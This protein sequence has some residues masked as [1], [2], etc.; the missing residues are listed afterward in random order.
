MDAIDQAQHTLLPKPPDYQG[1]YRAAGLSVA[2]LPS[3]ALL[4]LALQVLLFP[5][6][7]PWGV[8]LVA[9]E[10]LFLGWFIFLVWTSPNPSF[11]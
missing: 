3:L 8:G 2:L 9:A 6:G 10:A 1:R 11:P 5:H 4:C 7:T